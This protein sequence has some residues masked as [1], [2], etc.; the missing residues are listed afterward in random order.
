[1]KSTITFVH[2]T[3][4]FCVVLSVPLAAADLVKAREALEHG[5]YST[6]FAI[7]KTACAED[8]KNPEAWIVLG[9]AL[10]EQID[11]VSLFKKADLAKQT[12]A[13]YLQAAEIAPRNIEAHVSLLEYYRQAPAIVG[14]SRAKARA[15][16]QLLIG[17]DPAI[18]YS[19]TARLAGEDNRSNEAFAACE[20]LLRCEPE[21]YR[22]HY[23]LGA[24]C[25]IFGKDLARGQSALRHALQLTPGEDDPGLDEANIQLGR[26]LEKLGDRPGA[27]AAYQAALVTN[28]KSAEARSC[29]ERVK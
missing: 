15:E 18:G 23:W 17:L 19:W 24:T 25:Q 8:A 5:D 28:A 2:C 7:A 14:G 10:S 26:L 29:L 21:S 4:L 6:A 16:A 9:H 27:A 22:S 20:A 11:H 12:L 1:M 13:A 3:F